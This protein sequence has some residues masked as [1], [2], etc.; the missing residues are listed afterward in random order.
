VIHPFTLFFREFTL[1]L[2]INRRC[3]PLRAAARRRVRA[4]VFF[5]R[6]RM[7]KATGRRR[8]RCAWTG[9]A[10]PLLNS[11]MCPPSGSL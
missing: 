5:G 8:Y 7:A 9:T 11:C 6:A 10:R 1:D 2:G 3:A 4:Q